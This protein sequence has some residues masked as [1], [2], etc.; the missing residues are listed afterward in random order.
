MG[1]TIELVVLSSWLGGAVLVAAVVA[2]AAFAVLPSRTMAGALV[3]QV[4]PVLFISGIVVAIIAVLC[5]MN[6]S[7]HAFSLKVSA[8]L[9]ALAVGCAVAQFVIS[10]KIER[11]RIAVGAPIESL[12]ATDPQRVAFGKLHAVSVLA[13]GV[14]MLGALATIVIQVYRTRH[15]FPS[16]SNDRLEIID[17]N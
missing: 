11:I 9:I 14:A 10:P 17:A 2:P 13:L 16:H 5:E 3:G 1:Q 6:I 7:R 8:P 4:L 15:N 12:A